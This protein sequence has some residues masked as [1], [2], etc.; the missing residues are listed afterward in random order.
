MVTKES[1]PAI[2]VSAGARHAGIDSLPVEIQ[3]DLYL[4][5]AS[6][7]DMRLFVPDG[8]PKSLAEGWRLF[9]A[10]SLS[11]GNSMTKEA[12]S[13]AEDAPAAWAEAWVALRDVAWSFGR[14][15]AFKEIR[16]MIWSAAKSKAEA[17]ST[18]D[19]HRGGAM[20]F[21]RDAVLY[22]AC[23]LV[24]DLDFEGKGFYMDYAKERMRVWE[25]GYCLNRDVNGTLYVFCIGNAADAGP[26]RR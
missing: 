14:Q 17:D 4:F 1:K 2:M 18:E 12:A 24:S 19:I 7:N 20:G 13:E 22:A 3:Q 25:K 9:T 10:S 8:E 23:L 5:E 21:P 26:T 11:R 16:D 6:M 15:R